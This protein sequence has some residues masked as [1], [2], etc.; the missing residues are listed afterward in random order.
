MMMTDEESC[1]EVIVSE[2][3]IFMECSQCY[4]CQLER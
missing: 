2:C 3:V 1:S 4:Y